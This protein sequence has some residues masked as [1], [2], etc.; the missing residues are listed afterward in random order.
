MTILMEIAERMTDE[1]MI[2]VVKSGMRELDITFDESYLK[3][4][5]P[6]QVTCGNQKSLAFSSENYSAKFI[7]S[8]MYIFYNTIFGVGN[9]S[10]VRTRLYKKKALFNGSRTI[11][12]EGKDLEIN[13]TTLASIYMCVS[14]LNEDYIDMG[15]MSQILSWIYGDK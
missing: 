13:I 10:Q 9:L 2:E 12:L 4:L 6:I 11:S 8:K 14:N 1:R 3:G 7:N 15:T 5:R